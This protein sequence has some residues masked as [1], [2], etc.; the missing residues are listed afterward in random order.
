MVLSFAVATKRS[1]LSP[2]LRAI[3]AL[4]SVVPVAVPLVPVVSLKN[5]TLEIP[6]PESAYP[7]KVAGVVLV[8][9][10]DSP[11]PIIAIEIE[12]EFAVVPFSN[13]TSRVISATTFFNL[14]VHGF[15]TFPVLTI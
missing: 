14:Y 11:S 15:P 2:S 4:H 5:S 10:I 13:K 9:L 3:A 12:F 1:V 8:T 7:A 6:M